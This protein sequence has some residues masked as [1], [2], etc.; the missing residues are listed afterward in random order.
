MVNDIDKKDYLKIIQLTDTHL[1]SND[2]LLFGV[3]CNRTFDIVTNNLF[4]NE[5]HDTDLI[6]LTGDL[7]QDESFG[8]YQHLINTFKPYQVPV[9]WI[10]GNHDNLNLMNIAFS[11]SP[12]FFRRDQL[13]LKHWIFIFLNTQL[14]GSINGF[15]NQH[16]LILIKNGIKKAALLNKKIALIMHHHPVSLGTPLIDKYFINNQEELWKIIGNTKVELA[17]CGHVHGDYTLHHNNVKV[18]SAPATCFQFKKGSTTLEIENLVGYKTHY[19]ELGNHRSK[20]V[21]WDVT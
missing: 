13:E 19:F 17:I 16:D 7:S 1:F 20:S 4:K 2:S 15:I 3:N 18:E 9:F 11:V 14:E 8:S 6:L 10:P 21:I 5:L 12:L